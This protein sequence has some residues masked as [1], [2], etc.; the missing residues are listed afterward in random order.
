[1]LSGNLLQLQN[2]QRKWALPGQPGLGEVC[3]S[4]FFLLPWSCVCVG[5]KAENNW[6]PVLKAGCGIELVDTSNLNNNCSPSASKGSSPSRLPTSAPPTCKDADV[7][8]QLHYPGKKRTPCPSFTGAAGELPGAMSKI[9]HAGLAV[10]LFASREKP[11]ARSG[12]ATWASMNGRR[13]LSSDLPLSAPPRGRHGTPGSGLPALSPRIRG[14]SLVW[15][16]SGGLNTRWALN[17]L[18]ALWPPTLG[19]AWDPGP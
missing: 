12:A 5:K 18:L 16:G 15:P 7:A 4:S 6:H 8:F 1:M 19:L 13:Q 3:V 10:A 17:L 9:L 2:T 14:I 11:G